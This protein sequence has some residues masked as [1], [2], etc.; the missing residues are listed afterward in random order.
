MQLSYINP[1][2]YFVQDPESLTYRSRSE[3]FSNQEPMVDDR[4]V[5]IIIHLVWR[6]SSG[7]RVERLIMA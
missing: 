1:W 6:D 3:E 7:L 4:V 5:D 2:F